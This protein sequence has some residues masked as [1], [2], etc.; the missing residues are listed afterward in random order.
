[1]GG[2][3]PLGLSLVPF[4]VFAGRI[5]RRGRKLHTKTGVT[6]GPGGPIKDAPRARDRRLQDVQ[7]PLIDYSPFALRD[8]EE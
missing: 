8:P 6:P 7:N 3:F 4:L 2:L 1:M 5:D